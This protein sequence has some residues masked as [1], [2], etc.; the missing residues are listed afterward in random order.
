MCQKNNFMETNF[1]NQLSRRKFLKTS[2]L[3]AMGLMLAPYILSSEKLNLSAPLQKRTFGRTGFKVTTLGLGGQGSLQWTPASIDPVAIINKS[4]NMGINYFDTSNVYGPSQVNYGKAFRKLG[5]VPETSNYDASKRKAIFLNSKTLL[6]FAKGG[7]DRKDVYG[8]SNGSKGSKAL[9]D[10]HRSLSQIFG[11]GNGNYPNGAYLDMVQIHNLA[12]ISEI[13]ALYEGYDNLDPSATTIGALAA[14]RDLR[15]GT[16]RTGLNPKNEKLIRH[17]GFS[18]HTDPAV[19]IEM[20]QRDTENLL[21]TVLLPC[22]ANDKQYASMQNNVLPLTIAKNM[23]VVAMKIFADGAMYTNQ[24]VWGGGKSGTDHV[25]QEVSG[26]GVPANLLIRYAL[27]TPGVHTAII[28]IGKISDDADKCQLTYN[29]QASQIKPDELSET[30]RGKIELLASKVKDGKTNFFQKGFVGLTAPRDA[31]IAIDGKKVIITWHTSLAGEAPIDR[32]EIWRDGI[33]IATIPFKA[34]ITKTPY[35]F[36]DKDAKNSVKEY[37]VKVVD[38][39][40]KI[41]ETILKVQ[42]IIKKK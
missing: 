40:Q 41:A 22:N 36:I 7:D 24:A 27:T 33:K 2:A 13:D 4:Y 39:K 10:I 1:N 30:E 9:D 6:R 25:V 12:K 29:L 14:L 16:N 23:G 38:K 8:S 42:L 15:D 26:E 35:Q 11:D 28:G 18:G 19:M 31:K 34:Q 21:E 37:S 32:Y 20:I 17:I 3:G 5:L